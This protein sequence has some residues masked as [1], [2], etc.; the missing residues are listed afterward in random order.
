MIDV[1]SEIQLQTTRSGGKGGQN[2][3]KVETAAIAYFNIAS[4][5]ILSEEQKQ[6]IS[7]EAPTRIK[8]AQLKA[9]KLSGVEIA[10]L[11]NVSPAYISQVTGKRRP[12]LRPGS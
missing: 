5:K 9:L 2:V 1:S 11:L 4:S 8:A 12:K 7:A 6:I 10:R 3:N